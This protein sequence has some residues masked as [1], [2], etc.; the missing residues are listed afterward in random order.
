MPR[1][2]KPS[3]TR[4]KD[5]VSFRLRPSFLQ[6]LTAL[7]E[8]RQ[9]K[10]PDE[11]ARKFV[12]DTLAEQGMRRQVEEMQE[13]LTLFREDLVTAVAYVL[14]LTAKADPKEARRVAEQLFRNAAPRG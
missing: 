10:S 14:Q 11:L 9:E 1:P 7:A 8:E 13:Q 4:T 5:T 3:P 6:T 2:R 12:I